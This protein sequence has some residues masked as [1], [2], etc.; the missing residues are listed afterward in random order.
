MGKPKPPAPPDPKETSAAQT[1]TNIG[2]TIANNIMGMV[3]LTTPQGSLTYN[4]TGTYTYNDPFTGETY[5]LPR[6]SATQ[7][8]TPTQEEI[9]WHNE[10][11][12]RYLAWAA[13]DQANAMR[14]YLRGG[15]DATGMPDMV[16]APGAPKLQPVRLDT[17]RIPQTGLTSGV[18]PGGIKGRLDRTPRLDDSVA[19][20]G[21]SGAISPAGAIQTY[22][23]NPSLFGG[24]SGAGSA[25]TDADGQRVPVDADGQSVT[26]ADGPIIR[27]DA[28]T[29]GG[30]R[31][32]VGNPSLAG[33]IADVGSV[34]GNV[35]GQ[36][37]QQN[38][39][40]AGGIRAQ[41]GN[42]TLR[43][44]IAN[45]GSVSGNVARQ[46]VQAHIGDAGGI[47]RR[48]ARIGPLQT[49][50]GQERART[51][52]NTGNSLVDSYG[53]DFSSDRQRVEDALMARLRPD[54]E[55]D[56]ESFRARM[57]NQG[58]TP[59]SAAYSAAN[60]DF[61]RAK[62]DA[63]L[64]A[65]LAG[66]QE[67]SR[68]VGLEADRAAFTNAARGQQFNQNLGAAEFGNRA[69]AQNFGQNLAGA[70]FANQ[71][72]AQRYGQEAQNIV[73]QNAAQAQ[74]FGQQAARQQAF[75]QANAQRFAQDAERNRIARDAQ[76]QRFGQASERARFANETA[77][78]QFGQNLAAGQ[79]ANAAQGQRFGQ[80]EARQQAF[81][82]A[83][84]QRFA[85]DAERNRI[86]R[87]AQAQ[88]Y[89]QASDRA[90][91]ANETAGQQFGQ[92]LAA[93]QFTN[94]AQAQQFG[95]NQAQQQA[96]M[97]AN[98]Q[99]FGQDLAATN[100]RNAA[101]QGLFDQE[102]SRT[103]LANQAQAQRFGQGMQN[104]ALRNAASAQRF[105]QSAQAQA[106]QNQAIMAGAG[107]NNA[108]AGQQFG[109]QMQAANLDNSVRQQALQEQFAL[110]NQPLNEI[111]ALLSGSQVN[112]PNF[113][114]FQPQPFPMTDVAGNIWRNYDGQMNNYNQQM[115]ARGGIFGNLLGALGKVGSA[116]ISA[117]WF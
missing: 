58:I 52:F 67:Q 34:S 38:L 93:G 13:H 77:G 47:T 71:T 73:M 55:R 87:E 88:R 94:Q 45:V 39:G 75:N 83:S 80:L 51:G 60:E 43:G 17:S 19:V 23:E 97:A 106:A 56:E 104:A 79:F 46:G 95:Q 110:R 50:V 12:Q 49:G 3:D 10:H 105:D 35:A 11:A 1:G 109:Q 117:G 42:P 54:L 114:P 99:N 68:L 69:R 4:Q 82:A 66:G 37:V 64:S 5:T 89:G 48:T 101:R 81:N 91:F 8:L 62:N 21:S 26:D 108:I 27:Q 16:N 44:Q 9:N 63:R 24:V 25:P 115:Q 86:A 7:A 20:R 15:V 74:A 72:Q 107:F 18:R 70:N 59:G 32:Q 112:M 100:L 90:R 29:A 78:Q 113:T 92:N 116:G 14:Q 40:D 96:N 61:Q 85:Q 31:A 111:S 28:D 84:A 2:S 41:V 53:T 57:I 98:A 103:N 102:M 76:A 65:I 33:L 22:V 6:F 30:N 36:G